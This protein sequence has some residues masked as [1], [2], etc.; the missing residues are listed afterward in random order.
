MV[1]VGDVKFDQVLELSKKYLEPIPR[2]E[3]PP[4]VRTK[5]PEQMGERRVTLSKAAQLPIQ[6]FLYHVPEAKHPDT[7]VLDVISTVLSS[8]QSSRL[9]KHLVDSQLALSAGGGSGDAFDPT[10]FRVSIQP[11]SGVDPATTEKALF[12][13]LSRLQTEPVPDAELRKAKNQM[14]A[15]LYRRLKT[16]EGRAN[17]L[18]TYEVFQ[19]DYSKLFTEDKEIEAVTAADIQRVAQ[20]YFT[21]KNRTV[22]TLIPEKP[23]VKQ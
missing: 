1:I 12:E 16:I 17:L 10:V 20:K 19:G 2:R 8:G 4:P 13:E 15:S 5:E 7:R 6:I 9:Y 23:E 22:A 3:P 18:G 11:R 14:L 21:A